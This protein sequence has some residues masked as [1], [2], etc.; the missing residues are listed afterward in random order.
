MPHIQVTLARFTTDGKS[1]RHDVIQRFAG[2]QSFTKDDGLMGKLFVRHFLITRFQDVD[3][4][5]N[6][7]V[8]VENTLVGRTKEC[9]DT[10]L[11][12][13]QYP[14]KKESDVVP[15]LF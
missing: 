5:F 4:F 3:A 8:A 6:S 2:F 15:D 13:A 9:R 11:K 1:F 12:D 7:L 10:T 14:G